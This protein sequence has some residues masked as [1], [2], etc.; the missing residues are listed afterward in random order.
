MRDERNYGLDVYRIL[1]CLGVLTYH[2]MD[3]VLVCG[4]GVLCCGFL[5]CGFLLCTGIFS[6]VRVFAWAAGKVIDRICGNE[7]NRDNE[8]AIFMGGILGFGSFYPYRGDN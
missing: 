5:F 8:K 7:N 3:D 6:V 1:C 2:I 4:G